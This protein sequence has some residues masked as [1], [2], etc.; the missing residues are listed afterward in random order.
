MD[1]SQDA[2][3]TATAYIE[4]LDDSDKSL[5]FGLFQMSLM[6]ASPQTI[7]YDSLTLE[8]ALRFKRYYHPFTVELSF[9]H[10][11]YPG[12]EIPNFFK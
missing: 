9:T 8:L 2:I 5:A 7:Q 3:N 4:I 10:E 1:Y 11:K 12:T 6:N